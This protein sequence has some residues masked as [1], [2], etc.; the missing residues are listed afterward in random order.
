MSH[1]VTHADR[2]V[3]GGADAIKL[4]DLAA[5][6]D[7]TDLN[8]SATKHGLYPKVPSVSDGKFYGLYNGAVT[9]ISGS[10]AAVYVKATSNAGQVLTADTTLLQ[11]EDEDEDASAAWSTNTFT[12]PS[13]G[14]YHI[15]ASAGN[16]GTLVAI[17]ALKNGTTIKYGQG[18]SY[19]SNVDIVIRLAASDTITFKCDQSFTRNSAATLNV[20]TIT[21]VGY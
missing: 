21:K 8:V 17:Y 16:F 4:D 9:E 15:S 1:L 7:N 12:A 13:A 6:D 2:H 11:Y 18:V 10:S 3:S 19:Q 20:L 5:P 14:L